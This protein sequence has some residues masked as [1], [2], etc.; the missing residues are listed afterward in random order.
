MLKIATTKIALNFY[1]QRK[2]P[3]LGSDDLYL[4]YGRLIEKYCIAAVMI[5]VISWGSHDKSPNQTFMQYFESKNK[6]ERHKQFLKKKS[7]STKLDDK[8]CSQYDVTFLYSL[9]PVV[10]DD[11]NSCH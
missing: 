7:N 3:P 2:M 10:C 4:L 6:H 5:T 1:F 8:D 9:I 11:K